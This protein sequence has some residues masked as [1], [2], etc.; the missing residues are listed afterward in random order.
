MNK[1]CNTELNYQENTPIAHT[2]QWENDY[3]NLD[4]KKK[5]V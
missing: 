1:F 3:K 5:L 2:R 4:I